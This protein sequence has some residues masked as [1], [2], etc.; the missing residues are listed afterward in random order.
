MSESIKLLK[1]SSIMVSY[2]IFEAVTILVFTIMSARYLGVEQFGRLNYLLSFVLLFSMLSDLGTSLGITKLVANNE[3]NRFEYI[4]NGVSLRF[5]LVCATLVITMGGFIIFGHKEDIPL[6]LILAISEGIRNMSVYISY[7][8]RGFQRMEFEPFIMGPERLLLVIGGF[9]LFE[10]GYGIKEIIYLYLFARVITLIIAY[11]FYTSNYGKILPSMKK[12]HIIPIIK[13]SLPLATH[14]ISDRINTYSIPVL[15]TFFAGYV[16]TGIY[17]SAFKVILLPVALC[18]VIAQVLYPAMAA[19]FAKS[20]FNKVFDIYFYGLKTLFN[21]TFPCAAIFIAY[22]PEIVHILYGPEYYLSAFVL[23]QF[24]PY[25]ILTCVVVM[26]VLLLPAIDK[27][28]II[29]LFAVSGAFWTILG[30]SAFIYLFGLSGAVYTLL[31]GAGGMTVLY[32]FIIGKYSKGHWRFKENIIQVIAAVVTLS[33]L[34]IIKIS[35]NANMF[36]HAANMIFGV[37]VYYSA[38]YLF[39]GISKE[40]KNII[41]LIIS[42]VYKMQIFQI[43]G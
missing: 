2:F 4:N 38:L 6:I 39:G 24:T 30:G 41:N 31:I 1:N 29:V 18:V 27:Q 17:Q 40:E 3:V 34:M 21:L 8:F 13:E 9:I 32:I 42:K 23:R 28:K 7:V 16:E 37:I 33:L 25:I 43:E 20:G 12:L 15:I 35:I 10:M 14:V 19:E 5:A 36:V 26:S 11:R 22:A